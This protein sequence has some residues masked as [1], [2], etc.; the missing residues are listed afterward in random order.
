MTCF[1]FKSL[2]TYDVN[3]ILKIL[4]NCSKLAIY[5]DRIIFKIE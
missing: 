4:Q 2:F 3:V 5:S 1:N